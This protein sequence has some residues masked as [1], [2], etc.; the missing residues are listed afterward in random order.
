MS[1]GL[2]SGILSLSHW[3][4]VVALHWLRQSSFLTDT[5]VSLGV[6]SSNAPTACARL[7]GTCLLGSVMMFT[8]MLTQLQGWRTALQHP[9]AALSGLQLLRLSKGL[10]CRSGGSPCSHSWLGF[11]S[12]AG[13]QGSVH[14]SL[15]PSMFPR[16]ARASP[17]SLLGGDCRPTRGRSAFIPTRSQV[18]HVR[19]TV[20]EALCCPT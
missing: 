17:R 18:T 7:S 11:P 5:A 6:R 14:P 13:T 4:V 1:L 20:W 10:E 9:P 15:P 16:P 19:V 12:L 2:V 8:R 3:S